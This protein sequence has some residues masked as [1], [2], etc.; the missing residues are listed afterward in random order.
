MID[1]IDDGDNADSGIYNDGM[2]MLVVVMMILM[3]KMVVTMAAMVM[4]LVVNIMLT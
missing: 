3:M 4:M 1:C 2:K